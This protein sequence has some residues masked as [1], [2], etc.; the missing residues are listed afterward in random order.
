MIKLTLK[1]FKCYENKT[2]E[3]DNGF[4]LIEG[5]SGTGKTSILQAIIFALFGKGK[6][7]KMN[8]KTSCSVELEFEDLVIFRSKNPNKLL[9][10]S[11]IE[12]DEAQNII[13]K[14]FGDTFD[15][16]SYISQT[17]LNSFVLM[18]PIEKLE[19]LEKFAFKDI[20]LVDIKARNKIEITKRKDEL[21]KTIHNLELSLKIFEDMDEP[22]EVKFPIESKPSNYEKITKNE[23]IKLKNCNVRIKK[24][25]NEIKKFQDELNDLKILNVNIQNK[26][27]N[28]NKIENLLEELSLEEENSIYDNDILIDYK[29]R[30]KILISKNEL[31]RKQKQ[32]SEDTKKIELMKQTEI[33][34]YLNEIKNINS[35]LWKDYSKEECESLI[36]DTKEY[37]QDANKI[38]MYKK[39]LKEY[40]IDTEKL[41]QNKN[42]KNKLESELLSLKKIYSN[43]I[44]YKCPSCD[45]K[46]KIYE[47]NLHIHDDNFIEKVDANINVEEIKKKILDIETEIKVLENIIIKEENKHEK[48]LKIEND[49]NEIASQYEDE[50]NE[51]SLNS[52]LEDLKDYYNYQLKQEKKI[53]EIENILSEEKFS[54]SFKI[55]LR[56]LDKLK[57]EIAN[58]ENKV[59]ENTEILSEEKLREIIS[60]EEKKKDIFDRVSK[61]KQ[62]KK[63]ENEK[64]KK[65]IE[66]LKNNHIEK[67]EN[68]KD[69]NSLLKEI[70]DRELK[71]NEYENDIKIHT[72]NLEKIN[73]YNNYTK[74]LDKYLD[75]KNKISELENKEK[76]DRKKYDAAILL[77]EKI[78]EAESIAILNIIETINNHSQVY[79]D[80]FFPDNPI[81]VKLQSFKETKK[82]NKPQIIILIDYKGSETD[83]A[84]LSGGE[85]SRVVLA[86]TLALSE[87]F[88]SPILLLDE[89]TASLDQDSTTIVFDAIK[90]NFK[91][92][93]VLIVAHQVVLGIFDNIIKIS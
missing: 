83:L 67:Y 75:F 44:L 45:V 9:V 31:L 38:S 71:I 25:Q 30:L 50:L 10:N 64:N 73:E 29:N 46:L 13:N 68:I 79:L 80:Y 36:N 21:T 24:T 70:N 37:I 60:I 7:I 78:L 35:N 23:E 22:K 5:Q 18:N 28:L 11:V 16:I 41:N 54:G 63:T 76:E 20:N 88:N 59:G 56:D 84:S 87:I 72:I 2:F 74:N 8:G 65:E 40:K 53:L 19:F 62:K 82:D 27:D 51:E 4:V 49:I 17:S 52:E 69:E 43:K 93:L 14:K 42:K 89:S 91:N 26:E 48:Y 55:F 85:L 58:I 92:K 47:N 15:V 6:N 32:F 1:N 12:N 39:T 86:F 81:I 77:K 61:E 57:V 34:K 33:E 3:F 90:E 66:E